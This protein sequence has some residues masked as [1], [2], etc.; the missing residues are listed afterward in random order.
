[1]ITTGRQV[2]T[3]QPCP[4][5]C[6]RHWSDDEAPDEIVHS[7]KV[8]AGGFHV[9][10]EQDDDRLP[11]GIWTPQISDAITAGE[12]RQLAAALIEAADLLQPNKVNRR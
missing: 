4:T 2:T 3:K 7:R 12:A 9:L 8:E 11:E 6:R 5:W 10:V 1:M